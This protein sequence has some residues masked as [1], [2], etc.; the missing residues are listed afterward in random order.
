MIGFNNSDVSTVLAGL[1]IDEWISSDVDMVEVQFG[2]VRPYLQPTRSNRK[3]GEAGQMAFRSSIRPQ[4]NTYLAAEL[5]PFTG[6]YDA[7]WDVW[8]YDGDRYG[9]QPIRSLVFNVDEDGCARSVYIPA[10][11][12]TLKKTETAAKYIMR[13]LTP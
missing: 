1:S 3:D 4:W 8:T 11:R 7:N 6:F 5:G 9:N 13:G 10:L 2:G 12:M